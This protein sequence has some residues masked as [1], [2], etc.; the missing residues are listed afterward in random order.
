M[1]SRSVKLVCEGGY[2]WYDIN[3]LINEYIRLFVSIYFSAVT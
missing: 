3:L 2:R 1:G